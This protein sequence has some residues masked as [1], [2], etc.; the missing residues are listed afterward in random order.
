MEII[1]LDE[2]KDHARI[3]FDD[4]DTEIQAKVDAANEYVSKMLDIAEDDLPDYEPPDDLKQ[5]V[6]MIAAH[7]YENREDTYPGSI[8]EVP[9]DAQEILLNHRGW[10]F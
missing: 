3:D 1:T 7:W 8:N 9:L 6:M 2:F 4:M 10:A 5:A